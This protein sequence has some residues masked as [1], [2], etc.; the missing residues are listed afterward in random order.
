MFQSGP[1]DPISSG[2]PVP[3]SSKASRRRTRLRRTAILKSKEQST[4]LLQAIWAES[5]QHMHWSDN[6]REANEGLV[7]DADGRL[8][9][10]T[11]SAEHLERDA[12]G[13][14]EQI[15]ESGE[16]AELRD[17]GETDYGIDYGYKR[18]LETLQ[19]DDVCLQAL[20]WF[21][22]LPL[23]VSHGDSQPEMY[24]L[25]ADD[26]ET[27]ADKLLCELLDYLAPSPAEQVLHQLCDDEAMECYSIL[28][29]TLEN[30]DP[31]VPQRWSMASEHSRRVL[32]EACTALWRKVSDEL[33]LLET[34]EKEMQDMLG[35][36][37]QTCGQ[38]APEITPCIAQIKTCRDMTQ[39]SRQGYRTQVLQ[40]LQLPE[41]AFSPEQR[42]TLWASLKIP[43]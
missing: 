1:A 18:V 29:E 11:E 25:A 37:R 36:L 17:E 10:S 16:R 21:Q 40:I 20:A 35:Q 26:Q 3:P 41:L 32:W 23:D 42:G 9:Q 7:A 6:Q 30:A 2:D 31:D 28:Q 27:P 12:D 14:I 34:Q 22:A 24:D 4:G 8:G 19:S 38:A 43:N 5:A 39:K 15:T 33:R 13:Q